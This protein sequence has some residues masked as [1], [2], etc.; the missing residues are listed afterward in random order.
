MNRV[1]WNKCF[2]AGTQLPTLAEDHESVACS[3]ARTAAADTD[4]AAGA[5]QSS[6]RGGRPHWEIDWEELELKGDRI[7]I[8]SFGEVFRGTWRH[9]DV[10]VKKILEQNLDPKVLEV[11]GC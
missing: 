7:G 1:L 3:S 8:G 2:Q 9:T 5:R 6:D 4:A 10:A 11:R